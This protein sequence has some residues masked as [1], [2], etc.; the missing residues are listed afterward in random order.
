[1]SEGTLPAHAA[2]PW[3]LIPAPFNPF[4]VAPWALKPSL[5]FTPCLP[6]P[7]IHPAVHPRAGGQ[8]RGVPLGG[9]E[10]PGA[11]GG[12][13]KGQVQGRVQSGV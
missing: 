7:S 11:A 4:C 13:V 9:A 3:R 6:I 2:S 5:I 8:A 10:E 12:R 1:V